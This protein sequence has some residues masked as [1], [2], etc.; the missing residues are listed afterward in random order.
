MLIISTPDDTPV[1]QKLLGDGKVI[2]IRL[3]YKVQDTPRGL[4]DAFILGE[5]FIGDDSVCLIL[6][7]IVFFGQNMSQTLWKAMDKINDN[8]GACIFGYPVKDARAFG[9]V[10]FDEALKV[11]SIEEK[12]AH[13]KS[14]YA[15]PGLYFY[16]NRVV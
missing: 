2:G 7:D 5:D 11:V 8:G 12:P 15:V 1:Y 16:D 13:P 4:E 3:E 14:N 10:E 9:V 6:G